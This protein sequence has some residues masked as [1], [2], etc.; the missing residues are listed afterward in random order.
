MEWKPTLSPNGFRHGISD[1]LFVRASQ[2]IRKVRVPAGFSTIEAVRKT[3]YSRKPMLVKAPIYDKLVKAGFHSCVAPLLQEEGYVYSLALKDAK[4]LSDFIATGQRIDY[5]SA[6]LAGL[7]TAYIARNDNHGNNW[8]VAPD[9]RV[10]LIDYDDA[11]GYE[12][13][14]ACTALLTE[15]ESHMKFARRTPR[16]IG[17]VINK[18]KKEMLRQTELL[19]LSNEYDDAIKNWK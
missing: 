10:F 2:P 8:L 11:G 6:A 15:I 5:K 19:D 12:Y 9:G 18:I 7:A 16:Q 3:T 14:L 1:A 13:P 4:T 17:L